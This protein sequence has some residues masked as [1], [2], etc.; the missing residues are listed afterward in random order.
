MTEMNPA[1]GPGNPSELIYRAPEAE[2]AVAP[3]SD[4]LF[5]AYVGPNKG[6]YYSRCFMRLQ[7]EGSMISWNWPA[8]F[9]TGWWLLYRKMWLNAVLY[10]FVLPIA[11]SMLSGIVGAVTGN[12]LLGTALYYGAY[13]VIGFILAPMFANW[14]YYRHV[15]AKVA[16]VSMRFS[17]DEQRAAELSRIGGTSRV[18]AILI[19]VLVI[20]IGIIS[21]ITIPAYNDYTARA[22]VSEGLALTSIVKEAAPDRFEDIG[23]MA[24]TNASIGVAPPASINGKYVASVAYLDGT[25]TVTYGNDSNSAIDGRTLEMTLVAEPAPHWVC[26]SRTIA[27]KHLPAACR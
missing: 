7:A 9:V 18:V 12:I 25:I 20:L 16:K 2:T 10:W 5:A 27:E 23:T 6:D 13:F 26:S 3:Q 15:S 8:F 24:G 22:Q 14:L 11:L 1:A 21:A 17:S 19:P 4:D